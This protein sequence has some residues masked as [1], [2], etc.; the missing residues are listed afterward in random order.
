MFHSWKMAI[1]L[2]SLVAVA[3]AV[4]CQTQTPP[5]TT[6]SSSQTSHDEHPDE[7]ADPKVSAALAKLSPQDQP[8]AKAQQFCAVMTRSRLGSMG[9]PIKFEIK[10][11]TVFVCCSGCKAKALKNPNETLATVAGLKA[12]NKT[13]HP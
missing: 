5:A 12:A 11:E 6:T 4:G 2:L 13:T 3:L 1:G 9:T 7:A 10:G 8:I